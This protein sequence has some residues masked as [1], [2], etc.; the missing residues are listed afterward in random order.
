MSIPKGIKKLTG[1]YPLVDGIPFQLPVSCQNSPA[2]MAIFPI[3]AQRAKALMPNEVHPF[4]I[5]N[6][7][8]LVITVIDYRDTNI[9]KYIEYSI[10]PCQNSCHPLK[11][12][13]L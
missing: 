12:N 7:A 5:W 11:F 1:R 10:P 9:G 6:K 4:I 8:L 3:N 2:I 13:I